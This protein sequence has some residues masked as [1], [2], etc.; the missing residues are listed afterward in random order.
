VT[1][2]VVGVLAVQALAMIV[3]ERIFHRRRGLPRWERV[4]HPLDTLTV[5]GCLAFLFATRPTPRTAAVYGALVIASSLFVTKDE[6]VHT[7][8]C[9][10]GEHWVHAVLFVLHPTVLFGAGS[11]W[12]TGRLVPIVAVEVAG[13]VA[14]GVYQ[15]VYW[16]WRGSRSWQ[17][18]S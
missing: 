8:L 6:P 16:N 1:A 13:T 3:D 18:A 2:F 4:G 7:R 5:L 15:L 10:A 14:F 9:S 11:L 17:R 12:W